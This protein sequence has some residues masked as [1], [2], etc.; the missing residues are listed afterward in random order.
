MG[1]ILNSKQKNTGSVD[2]LLVDDNKMNQKVLSLMLKK[3]GYIVS[4]ASNGLEAIDIYKQKKFDLVLMDQQMPV[5]GGMDAAV[6]IRK[7][8]K[9]MKTHTPVIALTANA[10]ERVRDEC[11]SA[12]MDDFVTKP[13][14]KLK[15]IDI[16]KKYC[17]K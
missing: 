8:E 10:T 16:V 7:I 14:K 17:L 6:E 12:G 15:V 13:L 3:M 9:E 2:I 5:M 4:V 1:D 11:L